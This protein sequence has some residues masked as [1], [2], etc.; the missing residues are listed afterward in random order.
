MKEAAD[1]GRGGRA[2][3]SAL[4]VEDEPEANQL[5]AMLVQLRGYRTDSAFS[6]REAIDLALRR[7]PDLIF[8]DLMLPDTNGFEVC[9]SL[10][11]D[12]TT[13]AI[14]VVMVTARLAEENRAEGFRA[15]ASDYIPK[16][17]TPDQIFQAMEDADALRAGAGPLNKLSMP[18]VA[19]GDLAALRDLNRLRTAI[20]ARRVP[21]QAQCREVDQFL[22]RLIA[23]AGNWP[24]LGPGVPTP[25]LDCQLV[26]GGVTLALSD[27]DPSQAADPRLAALI[28][29][30]PFHRAEAGGDP[31]TIVLMLPR[32]PDPEV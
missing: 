2:M 14:P 16:P 1:S 30:G 9:R 20:L 6:G 4:I 24:R 22:H 21:T 13:A 31:S 10:K 12:P 17:Y 23:V 18:L 11:A 5:L 27:L 15:G 7:T 25:R 19:A 29:D 8:L 32:R 3:P 26:E 28:A